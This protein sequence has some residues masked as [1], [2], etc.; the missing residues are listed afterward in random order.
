MSNNLV[1]RTQS[2]EVRI[3]TLF[4]FMNDV[5]KEMLPGAGETL[6]L[7]YKKYYNDP[8]FRY[9]YNSGPQ[10]EAYARAE[11]LLQTNPM[12]LVTELKRTTTKKYR[13]SQEMTL[14]HFLFD[15]VDESVKEFGN[16][17]HL[18]SIGHHKY[19]LVS[20][21]DVRLF[22]TKDLKQQLICVRPE[23][24]FTIHAPTL[25]LR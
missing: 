13:T 15:L 17:T 25:R 1:F 21:E 4:E 11:F 10:V 7:A 14:D 23:R 8:Y 24:N 9:Q 6:A 20:T 18:F 3:C 19:A 22:T 12:K 16:P 5:R 2:G